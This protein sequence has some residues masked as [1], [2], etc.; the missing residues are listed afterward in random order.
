M[1]EGDYL[2]FEFDR[3]MYAALWSVLAFDAQLG[4]GARHRGR[5]LV[6]G[7]LSCC[8]LAKMV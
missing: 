8:K 4:W 2:A 3:I 5:D 6:N 1:H 7:L